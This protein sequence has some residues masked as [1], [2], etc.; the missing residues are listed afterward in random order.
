MKEA[1]WPED[2]E[3]FAHFFEK[4]AKAVAKT[5]ICQ[6]IFIKAQF[7]SPKHL[8]QNPSKHLKYIQ[9]TKFCL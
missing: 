9:Q 6:N 5:R 7:L 8:Q 2:S 1:G 4:I 3:K